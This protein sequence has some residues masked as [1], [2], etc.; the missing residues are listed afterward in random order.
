M[1]LDEEWIVQKK[2]EYTR[3]A[4]LHNGYYCPYKG[5]L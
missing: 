5:T 1:G 2:N 3:T 4:C